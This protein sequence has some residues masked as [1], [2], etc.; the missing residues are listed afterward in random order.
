MSRLSVVQRLVLQELNEDSD[1]IVLMRVGLNSRAYFA[2][3]WKRH[4][5]IDT[6]S[7]LQREGYLESVS[8][9][10]WNWCDETY[11]LTDKAR[12]LFREDL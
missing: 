1:T 3:R 11:V 6:L 8:D 7:V 2:K 5:R 10:K 9:P 4:V 12:D